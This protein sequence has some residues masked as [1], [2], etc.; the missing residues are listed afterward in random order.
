MVV[1]ESL[2][3]ERT[4]AESGVWPA[5]DEKATADAIEIVHKHTPDR[6]V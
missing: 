1:A 3:R 5:N 2:Q 6:A 4:V